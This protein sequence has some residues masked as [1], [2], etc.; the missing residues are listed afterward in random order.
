M[1]GTLKSRVPGYT[2]AY[3]SQVHRGA[4]DPSTPRCCLAHQ[5]QT[6][7]DA[8]LVVDFA[9]PR[10]GICPAPSA[11][12]PG[13][14]DRVESEASGSKIK[15]WSRFRRRAFVVGSILTCCYRRAGSKPPP[16]PAPGALERRLWV[17]VW[18]A[19]RNGTTSSKPVSR[20]RQHPFRVR[21]RGKVTIVLNCVRTIT[22][23]STKTLPPKEERLSVFLRIAPVVPKS[24]GM[25]F[26]DGPWTLSVRLIFLIATVVFI[27]Y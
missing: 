20:T 23:T 9:G 4:S 2:H 25:N 16:H 8:A 14:S 22:P 13:C 19:A 3:R 18:A 1:P 10:V 15:R 12:P 6:R 27:L 26:T 11:A 17:R 24:P 5:V 7:L 21:H